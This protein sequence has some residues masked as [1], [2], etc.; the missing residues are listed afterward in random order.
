MV[1][2]SG[3][4]WGACGGTRCLVLPLPQDLLHQLS[5]DMDMQEA[6]VEKLEKLEVF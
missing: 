5:K 2:E 4:V 1:L 3:D 6:D